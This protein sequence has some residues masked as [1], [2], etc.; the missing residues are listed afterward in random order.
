MP[1]PEKFR[2]TIV[3]FANDLSLTFPEYKPLWSKWID[4]EISDAEIEFLWT[5]SLSV[6]PE[7]FFDIL[8]EKADMFL[9]EDSNTKFL[10]GVD[11]KMLYHCPG[12]TDKTRESLWKYLQVILFMLIGSVQD[13]MD[14]GMAASLFDNIDEGDLQDKL[15][16]V[17]EN[18]GKFFQS[19]APS[20]DS[21]PSFESVFSELFEE[22]T[23]SKEE[24]EDDDDEEDPFKEKKSAFP[25]IPTPDEIHEHL[26]GL[27]DGKI[28]RLARELADDLG[29]D[30]AKSFGDDMKNATSTQEVL[31]KLM[32]DPTKVTGLVKTVGEKINQK[33]AAGDISQTEILNEAREMMKKMKDMGGGEDFTKM[34]KNMARGMGVNIP[35]GAKVDQNA[36]KQFEKKLS[37]RDKVLAKAQQRQAKK[38]ADQVAA[39][40]QREAQLQMHRTLLAEKLTATSSVDDIVATLGLEDTPKPLSQG[41]K[42]RLKQKAKKVRQ[43]EEE[44]VSP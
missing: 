36:F 19:A 39:L 40:A 1:V 37:M 7:R 43:V 11:F 33:L 22:S 32:K 14:F 4:P 26:K 10:P 28:G 13:K 18:L 16:D 20:T 30:L 31:Q 44:V 9:K 6:Y 12:I 15:K 8:N 3:D 25:K 2:A 5:Y 17:V 27:F 24:S 29:E 34:F 41:Q 23:T 42:K 35:K 38:A 21:S